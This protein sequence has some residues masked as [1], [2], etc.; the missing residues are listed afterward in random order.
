M[1]GIFKSFSYIVLVSLQLFL[2]CPNKPKTE[3]KL[4]Y[5]FVD[6]KEALFPSKSSFPFEGSSA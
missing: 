2:F 6:V 5:E 4:V 1:D 3:N